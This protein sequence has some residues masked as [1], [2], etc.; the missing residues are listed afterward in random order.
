LRIGYGQLR[1][2]HAEEG[3]ELGENQYTVSARYNL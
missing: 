1:L 3:C 2:R